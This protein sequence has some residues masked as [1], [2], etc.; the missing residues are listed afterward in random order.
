MSPIPT[1]MKLYNR[2]KKQIYKKMPI[3][4]AHRSGVLVKKYK[5][6]FKKKYGTKSPYKGK[7][8]TTTGLWFSYFSK[9]RSKGR[10][11]SKSR[12]KSRSR[13]K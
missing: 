5:S 10:S 3:H 7:R 9:S 12:S 1:D 8:P 2:I 6:L 11:R 4:S 13:S